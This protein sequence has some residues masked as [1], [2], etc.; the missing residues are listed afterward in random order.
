MKAY[1]N[2]MRTI[3]TY[4]YQRNKVA[5]Y[6]LLPADLLLSSSP[7]KILCSMKE[8]KMVDLHDQYLQ[9]RDE[10][11]KAIQDVL[12]STAFIKGPPVKEFEQELAKYIGVKHCIACGNGTDALQVAMMALDLQP[13]DEVIT[14]PFTFIAT[15]EVIKLLKLK[16]VLVD[17]DPHTF[18]IDPA[19]LETV[20]SNRTK[21]IVPVHLFGQTADME[22]INSFAKS[23]QL[24]IIEDNAQAIGACY[25]FADGSVLKAGALG[26]IACTS[27]F[28]SKNLGAYGDG[29]AMFTNDD[30]LAAQMRSMINHGMSK[31]RYYYDQVGVN[32]RLD[33]LQA[34][35]LRVKL[36]HLDEYIK[37]R[38]KVATIYD[39]AFENI[40]LLKIPGRNPDSTHVFHQYTLQVSGEKRDGLR[41]H[42]T[43]KKIPAMIYYPVSLH[44]Q[45]A[46]L[47]LAYKKG[48]FPV[49]EEICTK[50]LSL[51]VHTEMDGEQ[52]DYITSS[53]IEYFN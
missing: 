19:K 24:F 44:L 27:F 34:A 42:L 1:F 11:N 30:K 40:D 16:P 39:G 2:T 26:D 15:I 49:T 36:Q 48:D 28:P 25:T 23:H 41:Q 50:V 5:F 10:I 37:A 53:V 51:P 7:V 3:S 14:T 35:I 45:K 29:G 18:N 17:I 38:Q 32:S 43:E 33:T 21:A 9:H 4:S 13:G 46:Y 6:K 8:I 20:V 52:L 47:D 22:K 31:E 12:D